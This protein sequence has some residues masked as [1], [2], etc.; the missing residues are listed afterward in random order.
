MSYFMCLICQ[1]DLF[2]APQATER[3]GHVYHDSCIR[4]WLDM[5]RYSCPTCRHELEPNLLIR[6]QGLNQPTDE[7]INGAAVNHGPMFAQLMYVAK[8]IMEEAVIIESIQRNSQRIQD[9]NE[10]LQVDNQRLIEERDEAL[11]EN[12]ALNRKFQEMSEQL[13]KM[14]DPRTRIIEMELLYQHDRI[15]MWKREDEYVYTYNDIQLVGDSWC[16]MLAR[17]ITIRYIMYTRDTRLQEIDFIKRSTVYSERKLQKFIG[18]LDC[19]RTVKSEVLLCAHELELKKGVPQEQHEHYSARLIQKLH[20]LGASVI[21]VI[22]LILRPMEGEEWQYKRYIINR[23]YKETARMYYDG[24]IE[25]KYLNAI[26]MP[27]EGYS[28][29]TYWDRKC[30]AVSGWLPKRSM[31]PIV[32]KEL[33]KAIRE[34]DIQESVDEWTSREPRPSIEVIELSD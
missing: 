28:S 16:Y 25:I 18:Q 12:A 7:L 32:M 11:R 24:Q 22:P 23:I 9:E 8:K 33:E 30:A 4:T 5:G 20:D 1:E 19:I 26:K 21:Y 27:L 10:Q 3:C 6:L 14:R 34:V 31:F 13:E 17:D 15:K 2:S 29:P